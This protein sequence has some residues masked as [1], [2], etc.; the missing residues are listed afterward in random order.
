MHYN[1]PQLGAVDCNVFNALVVCRRVG[2]INVLELWK[3]CKHG[4]VFK[5]VAN[6]YPNLSRKNQRL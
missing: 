5:R 2:K 4:A 6:S 1:V 3:L